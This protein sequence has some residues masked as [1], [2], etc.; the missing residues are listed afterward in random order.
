[1]IR[2]RNYV[3]NATIKIDPATGAEYVASIAA[4]SAL[5]DLDFYISSTGSD[6]SGT[7]AASAPFRSLARAEVEK[8]AFPNIGLCVMRLV[9]AGPFEIATHRYKG[10]LLV[11]LGHDGTQLTE[12]AIT[13]VMTVAANSADL[14]LRVMDGNAF[15]VDLNMG[16]TLVV[17]SGTKNQYRRMLRGHQPKVAVDLVSTTNVTLT[18]AQT[19]DGVATN[20]KRVLCAAQTD[21]T[22]RTVYNATD[23]GTWTVCKDFDSPYEVEDCKVTVTSGTVH[24]G[25]VWFQRAH[26]PACNEVPAIGYFL[27]TDVAFTAALDWS[28]AETV[29]SSCADLAGVLAGDTVQVTT[30]LA[31]MMCATDATGGGKRRDLQFVGYPNIAN[32][33]GPAAGGVIVANVYVD[34]PGSLGTL[35]MSGSAVSLWGVRCHPTK[36]Q[37]LGD[38]A[39]VLAGL[40]AVGLIS[41][42]A[43]YWLTRLGIAPNAVADAA[44]WQGWGL[45]LRRDQALFNTTNGWQAVGYWLL[46]FTWI[47]NE[48]P[49]DFQMYGGRMCR[50]FWC[51]AGFAGVNGMICSGDQPTLLVYLNAS[52]RLGHLAPVIF[53]SDVDNGVDWIWMLD[54]GHV[55]IQSTHG[56]KVSGYGIRGDFG[57]TVGFHD[58]ISHLT[59]GVA[60]IHLAKG[61]YSIS[62]LLS[63]P[64]PILN[65]NVEPYA[66]GCRLQVN[67]SPIPP[68]GPRVRSVS[69]SN[70][71]VLWTDDLL[72]FDNSVNPGSIQLPDP[73]YRVRP[74]KVKLKADPAV[75]AVSMLRHGGEKFEFV[76]G[77]FAL[78]SQLTGIDTDSVDWYVA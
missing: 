78:T 14:A 57:G 60:D 3:D 27:A 41:N 28:T 44:G 74:F 11:I 23:A 7:G 45:D 17:R 34:S 65:D 69:G 68:S 63:P 40:G 59:G 64:F 56:H 73:A 35:N 42:R 6:T 46:G 16:A 71:A 32:G 5:T 76:A 37:F 19:V 52:V 8:W 1:M 49:A 72:V 22:K 20:G 48:D 29:I 13:G 26:L 25:E 31:V 62:Y 36:I 75:H 54:A 50:G 2:T 15:D 12:T 4:A 66:T 9:D 47:S 38:G 77:D 53:A 43:N 24:H 10:E 70:V 21:P 58:Q 18:G 51:A 30:P 61:D 39:R 67:E 33:F 55:E